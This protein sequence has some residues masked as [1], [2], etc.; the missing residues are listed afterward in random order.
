MKT[1]ELTYIVSSEITSEE[2]EAKGKEIESAISSKEGTILKQ[3]NPTAKTFSYPIGKNASGFLGVLEFQIDTEKLVELQKILEKDVKIVRHML[4]IKK[5]A[6][7]KKAR[8][9]REKATP[10]SAPTFE[11]EKKAAASEEASLAP[12]GREEPTEKSHTKIKE[13]KEKVEL[14]DIEHELDEI[15][16]E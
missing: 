16:G 14:K 11:I 7:F 10:V 1:Y 8:R 13:I 3:S 4:I 15:L 12:E 9:T 2:A 5:A 6:E